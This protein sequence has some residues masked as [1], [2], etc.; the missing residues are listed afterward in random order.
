MLKPIP[1]SFAKKGFDHKQIARSGNIAIYERSRI[2]MKCPHWEVVKIGHHN[3]Y[4]L[5]G[6]EI[7]PSETYPSSES[8]GVSGWTYRNLEKAKAKFDSLKKS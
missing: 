6:V 2:G 5:A 1:A 4:I 3:G 7:P 8:W